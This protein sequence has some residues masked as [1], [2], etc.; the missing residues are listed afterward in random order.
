VSDETK[1]E[2]VRYAI[3]G[4]DPEEMERHLNEG[5]ANANKEMV[6]SLIAGAP[7]VFTTA[8]WEEKADARA[9]RERIIESA[10]RMYERAPGDSRQ[11]W[12]HLNNAETFET[13]ADGFA[14]RDDDK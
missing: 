9:R 2:T 1:P 4:Y 6:E 8:G 14:L 13:A 12:H 5:F 10:R 11:A 7:H 3:P